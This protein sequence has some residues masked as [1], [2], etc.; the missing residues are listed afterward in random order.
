MCTTRFNVSPSY[1]LELLNRLAKVFKD[2]CGILT[3]ESI[4]K[5]F[6][7]IY[8]LL[9]EM[10]DYGYPQMT[11]TEMLKSCIHNEAI[12]TA[13]SGLSSTTSMIMN[14]AS[15]TKSSAASSLPVSVGVSNK[16]SKNKNEIYVDIVERLTVLFNANGYVVNSSIDGSILMK[17]FLSG[18]PELRLALNEDLVI[19]KGGGS[20]GSVVFDDC[21][22]HECVHLDEFESTRTLHFI[23][24]DGEFSVLNY[25]ITADFRYPFKIFPSIDETGP[26]KIELLILVRSDIPEGSHATNVA[27]KIPVPRS[28]I[29]ATM[30]FN[31]DN[32][33]C[34]A[35]FSSAE[36]KI[37]WNIR[38]VSGGSEVSIRCKITLDQPITSVIKREIGPITMGFEIPMHNASN[39]QVRYLR[40]SETH[41]SYNPFR[42]VRYITQS[43]SYVCR[44]NG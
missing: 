20:Y 16:G 31:T 42:W 4:R 40:I 17:S 39:L 9:D 32:P 5:N 43:T 24:P 15:K 19:G 8:E 36:K 11:S 34:V 13:P 10:I 41:R 27:F 37:L 2:Y 21:N 30:E 12:V 6:I 1:T 38:K 23:P 7:L 22:F 3:E 44:V 14:M 18:N 35:E 26:N 33:G 29:Q 28:T 25:R